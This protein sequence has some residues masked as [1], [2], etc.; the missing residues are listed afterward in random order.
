M[1]TMNKEVWKSGHKYI[2]DAVTDSNYYGRRRAVTNFLEWVEEVDRTDPDTLDEITQ[3]T[4]KRWENYQNNEVGYHAGVVSQRISLLRGW[5]VS[6]GYYHLFDGYDYTSIN[7]E[8]RKREREINYIEVEEYKEMIKPE[9][10]HGDR[11]PIRNQ[12]IIKTGWELGIRNS[13]LCNLKIDVDDLELENR[14]FWVEAAK[15]GKDHYGYFTTRYKADLEDYL[16][17][18]DG[19]RH[20][21]SPY[22]FPSERREKISQN[23][24][25]KIVRK[26]ATNAGIQEHWV[27]AGGQKRR[28]VNYST[29]RD[30]FACHRI[31]N[32]MDIF[33]L[34]YL[35]GHNSVIT[36]SYYTE[37][38]QESYREA[39]DMYSPKVIDN[40]LMVSR[41]I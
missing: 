26:S 41:M 17:V 6:E 39:N 7:N 23:P 28:K 32:N 27:D 38:K 18:R 4:I 12:M 15:G 33:K 30:S 11:W 14:R 10:V 36:T 35:M 25:N 13:E 34:S 37:V 16:E 29:L 21:D 31:L 24:V 3:N 20:S 5:L 1:T 19:Y 40:S 22:L 8:P 9:N 2:N